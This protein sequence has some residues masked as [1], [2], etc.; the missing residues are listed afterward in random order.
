[1]D[2]LPKRLIP[3]Y[4]QTC[5]HKHSKFKVAIRFAL[6]ICPI[7]LLKTTEICQN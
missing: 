1:M 2:R 3:I 6:K 7:V 5:M 4:P